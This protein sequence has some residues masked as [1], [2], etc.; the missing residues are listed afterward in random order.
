MEGGKRFS[1]DRGDDG[2]EK[3]NGYFHP[4]PLCQRGEPYE[5]LLWHPA[6][7]PRLEGCLWQTKMIAHELA[8]DRFY[9]SFVGV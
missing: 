5:V 2:R 8:A 4:S 6:L 7:N 9:Q 1:V 3:L